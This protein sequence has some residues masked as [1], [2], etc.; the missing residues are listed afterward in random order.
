[1]AIYWGWHHIYAI[2]PNLLHI[3]GWVPPLIFR[4]DQKIQFGR[5][6]QIRL[7]S[8]EM[9]E[10]ELILDADNF[11]LASFTLPS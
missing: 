7:W 6:Q 11:R 4:T 9:A 1:M 5:R 3:S 10:S 8:H 2:P